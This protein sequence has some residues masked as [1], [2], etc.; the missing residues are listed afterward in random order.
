MPRYIDA[1][2]ADVERIDCYYGSHCC[3]QDVEAWLEE[4]PTENV[5]PK[6][7]V[8]REIFEVIKHRIASLEYKANTPRKTVKIEELIVQVDWILHVV[9]PQTLAELEKEFIGEKK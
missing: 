6:S 7:E 8:A 4:L 9:I 3:L 1:D 2:K 5:A